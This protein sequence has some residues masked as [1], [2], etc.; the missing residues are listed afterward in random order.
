MKKNGASQPLAYAHTQSR[1][2]GGGVR[3]NGGAG[4]EKIDMLLLE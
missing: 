3:I 2:G 4:R 1:S